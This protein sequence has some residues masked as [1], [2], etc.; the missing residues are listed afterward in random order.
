MDC[1]KKKT[2]DEDENEN[3]DDGLLKN[4]NQNMSES[5][6]TIKIAKLEGDDDPKAK[7]QEFFKLFS[8]I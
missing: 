5:K 1:F 2:K 3:E 4:D 8:R 7:V 6:F